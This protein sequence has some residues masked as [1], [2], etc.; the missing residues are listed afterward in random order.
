MGPNYKVLA[1]RDYYPLETLLGI[2]RRKE[3][4][5]NSGI[6]ETYGSCVHSTSR[7]Q[8]WLCGL[9]HGTVNIRNHKSPEF[10]EQSQRPCVQIASLE[11]SS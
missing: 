6:Y 7:L 2:I 4:P 5:L 3:R 8:N 11:G 10:P 9:A 1:K